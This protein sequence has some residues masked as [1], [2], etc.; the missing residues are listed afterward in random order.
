MLQLSSPKPTSTSPPN[1]RTTRAAILKQKKESAWTTDESVVP[2]SPPTELVTVDVEPDDADS[3]MEDDDGVG[4]TG[5]VEVAEEGVSY[6]PPHSSDSHSSDSH[7]SELPTI[8]PEDEEIQ[9]ELLATEG[10]ASESPRSI[11]RQPTEP[12]GS[13]PSIQDSL[14][15]E[16]ADQVQAA[17]SSVNLRKY[18]VSSNSV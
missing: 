16:V 5:D 7:S 14:P 4:S 18:F 10:S 11:V 6:N 2:I 12:L 15:P 1:S 3:K 8:A 9:R 13:P 17:D